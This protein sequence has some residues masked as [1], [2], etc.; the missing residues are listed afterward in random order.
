MCGRYALAQ[1]LDVID[2]QFGSDSSGISPMPFNWNIAPTQD[3]YLVKENSEKKK[4]V[5]TSL[6]GLIPSWATDP[7]FASNTINA[8]VETIAEKPSFRSAFRSR[9]CLIPASGYYEWATEFGQFKSKQPFYISNKDQTLLPMAGIYEEW[10]NP[11]TG[12]LITSAAIITRESKDFIAKIHHRMPIMLPK[13]DWESWLDPHS[14][15]EK[16]VGDYLNLL[17]KSDPTVGLTAWPVSTA[18]NSGRSSGSQLAQQIAL[19]EP[20]TLF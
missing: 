15:N 9:R 13:D 5:A 6:W 3:I 18:V 8:R 2:A 11:Q 10:V 12:E 19:G 16:E 17:D 7:G 14:L 20:E 1:G 4:V